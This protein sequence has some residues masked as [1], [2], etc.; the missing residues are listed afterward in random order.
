M[1]N[2]MFEV[3]ELAINDCSK[4]WVGTHGEKKFHY[5]GLLNIIISNE[6][7]IAYYVAFPF[8]FHIG[9]HVAF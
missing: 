7:N 1:C 6:C 8:F 2:V 3:Y 5:L 4:K 9:I